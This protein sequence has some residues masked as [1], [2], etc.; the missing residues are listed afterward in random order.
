MKVT[1]VQVCEFL[2]KKQRCDATNEAC[3]EYLET[4]SNEKFSE[5]DKQKVLRKIRNLHIQLAL[6]LNK[7]LAT[8]RTIKRVIDEIPNG[9]GYFLNDE[10]KNTTASSHKEAVHEDESSMECS[11]EG[12]GDDIESQMNSSTSSATSTSIKT[13][14]L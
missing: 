6:A 10:D 9:K 5:E 3:V 1:T 2:R 12:E 7:Q 11:N 4:E 8:N 14:K 13:G